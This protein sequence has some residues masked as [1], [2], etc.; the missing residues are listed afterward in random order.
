MAAM[1][2][3]PHILLATPCFGG[4]V[5]TAYMQSVMSLM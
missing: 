1:L 3:R 2:E 5:T 4:L